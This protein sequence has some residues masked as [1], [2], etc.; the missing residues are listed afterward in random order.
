MT[1]TDRATSPV[2]TITP[3]GPRISLLRAIE[4]AAAR[5]RDGWPC[6]AHVPFTDGQRLEDLT[7]QNLYK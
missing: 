5:R 4:L 2:Y 1:A 6:D 3:P 7:P